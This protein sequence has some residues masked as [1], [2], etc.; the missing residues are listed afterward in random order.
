MAEHPVALVDICRALVNQELVY[1]YQPII[2]LITGKICAAEALIRWK[3]EDE[4]ILLPGEFIP[5]AE[6]KGLINDITREMLPVLMKD[7]RTFI[8]QLE[9]DFYVSVNLS[10]KDITD[11][12][13]STIFER[14][15]S[16]NGIS[17]SRVCAEITEKVFMPLNEKGAANI[18]KLSDQGIKIALDDFSAGHST[19]ENLTNLPIS[20]LKLAMKI[21]QLAP[22]TR[23]DFRLLRHLVSLA[24]QLNLDTIAEGVET[25]EEFNL[26]TSTGCTATQGFYFSHPLPLE[27]FQKLLTNQPSW[28]EYPFGLEYLAQIDHID[29]RRDII[30]EALTIHTNPD[31]NARKRALK[32]LPDLDPDSCLMG[33]WFNNI[34]WQ[35]HEKADLEELNKLHQIFHDKSRLLMSA[36]S[37]NQTRTEINKLI[38]ELT[39]ISLQL[40]DNL[41]NISIIGIQNHYEED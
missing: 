39:E 5:L 32:R 36:A 2:S 17:S 23:N 35:W 25:K 6:E 41:Q 27:D 14:E 29:F 3:K 37:K 15:F 11:D 10:E 22:S 34:N 8:P 30:R 1:Y 33:K 38:D 12:S 21:T 24:H 4:S 9:P 40:M 19:L 7:I 18:F 13:L 16:Q 28:S 31:P 20:V 26:L